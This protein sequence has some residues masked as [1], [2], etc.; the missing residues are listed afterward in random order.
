MILKSILTGA[1][2]VAV[3]G[4][5]SA[6]VFVTGLSG[7]PAASSTS[8]DYAGKVS[9]IFYGSS[10][11][12]NI[13]ALGV[14]APAGSQTDTLTV[15]LWQENVPA[16][17]RSVSIDTSAT[18]PDSNGFIYANIASFTTAG[19]SG[20]YALTVTGYSVNKIGDSLAPSTD[21]SV[22]Y[23]NSLY[24]AISGIINWNG[25]AN[26]YASGGFNDATRFTFASF[27]TSPVPE[28][29]VYASIA[30][31]ALVGFGLYRRQIRK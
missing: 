15:S 5:V 2:V 17:L 13:D 12:Y 25:T 7:S 9:V 11:P 16:P 31:L 27:T 21:P 10:T 4:N 6:A 30:G 8:A 28:P 29:E 14:Y 19:T 20:H 3:L 23:D 26:P 18:T 24:T 1:A 22:A